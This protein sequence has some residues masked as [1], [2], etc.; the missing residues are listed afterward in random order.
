V[1]GNFQMIVS[2]FKPKRMKFKLIPRPTLM[3]KL[4]IGSFLI[5]VASLTEALAFRV[6]AAT[7]QAP[8]IR[9]QVVDNTGAPL[10]GVTVL[11]KGTTVGTATDSDGNYVLNIPE[12]QESGTVIFSFVGFLTEEANIDGRSVIDINMTEDVSM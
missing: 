4:L 7:F 9:G 1:P 5:V 3:S 8:T 11:I 2:Q 10:A 6:S 12:G